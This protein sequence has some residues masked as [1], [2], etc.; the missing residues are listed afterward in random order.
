M[1]RDFILFSLLFFL[2]AEVSAASYPLPPAGNQLVGEVHYVETQADETLLDIARRFDIGYNEITSAN[3]HVDPWLPEVGTR[4]LVPTRF[5][6]PQ[7][8]WRDI[9]VNLAEMRLYYFP[10]PRKG[11][12][13]TVIT[14][15]IGIGREGGATPVGDFQI[16]MKIER[17]NWTMPEAVYNELLSQGIETPRLIPSGPDNPLGE[18]AMKLNADGLFIHGTNKPFSIGMRVTLGCLR[19]YPED[20][21]EFV[22]R[23]PKGMAVHIVDQPYKVGTENGVVFI[24]AHA[25]IEHDDKEKSVNMTPVVAGVVAGMVASVVENKM[26]R[27]SPAQWDYIVALAGRHTGVPTAISRRAVASN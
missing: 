24:E 26:G 22:H 5:V 12:T 14:H 18:Y 21:N 20:I 8:P 6:L 1:R 2:S 15:P 13:P 4:V 10:P 23:V 3:P 7:T 16:V 27:L 19:L 17:P 11:E 9:V 25:P